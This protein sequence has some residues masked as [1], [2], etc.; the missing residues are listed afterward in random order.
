MDDIKTAV[1]GCFVENKT[2]C[3]CLTALRPIIPPRENGQKLPVLVENK[4]ARQR[5]TAV[6]AR[7]I[8]Q[9]RPLERETVHFLAPENASARRAGQFLAPGNV[10]QR[11]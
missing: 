11:R 4:F 9:K 8:V 2:F 1:P 7:R 10:S 6:R 5:Q 3:I